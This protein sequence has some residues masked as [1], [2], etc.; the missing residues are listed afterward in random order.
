[1]IENKNKALLKSFLHE[2]QVLTETELSEGNAKTLLSLW[3]ECFGDTPNQF[4]VV[5]RANFLKSY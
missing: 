5:A 2:L 3:I 4:L 1:M